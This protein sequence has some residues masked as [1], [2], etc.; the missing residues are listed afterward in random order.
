M[1]RRGPY[2][3]AL[4]R[5]AKSLKRWDLL[6]GLLTTGGT[7]TKRHWD[8]SP[9]PSLLQPGC[10]VNGFATHCYHDMLSCHRSK[11]N[12]ANQSWTESSKTV[13]QNIL[14]LFI[15]WLSQLLSIVKKSWLTHLGSWYLRVVSKIRTDLWDLAPI[16]VEYESNLTLT[17]GSQNLIE[18]NGRTPSWSWRNSVV[19]K[20]S[21]YLV[22][23]GKKLPSYLVSEVS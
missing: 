2:L 7:P 18:L 14:F 19:S 9:A 6:G 23:G 20:G 22:S 11:I 17:S 21:M 15:C 8:P 3:T 12:E 1:K 5:G 4:L 10:K 16:P 13:I